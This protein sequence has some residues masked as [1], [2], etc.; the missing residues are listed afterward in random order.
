MGT[1]KSKDIFAVPITEKKPGET[2]IYRNPGC[3]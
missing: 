3:T 1:V 2:A